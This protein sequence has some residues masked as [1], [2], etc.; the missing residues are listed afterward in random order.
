MQPR[1]LANMLLN[2]KKNFYLII[3]LFTIIWSLTNSISR[4]DQTETKYVF[5]EKDEN[6]ATK[7][8]NKQELRQLSTYRLKADDRRRRSGTG[9]GF[10]IGSGYWL[11]ARHVINKCDKVYINQKSKDYLIE[12]I[13]IH[14][15]SDLALF[16]YSFDTPPERFK[17]SDEVSE[18][19]Y[20][21]GYPAG[22]PG[23]ASLSL[24][25]FM[26]MEERDYDIF[27]KHAIFAVL[28]KHPS[29]LTSFGGISGGPAF[30]VEGAINGVVVAEFVR[31]G[32][33]GV[34]GIDQI[35]W[36]I[37]A[38]KK[39]QYFENSTS[40]TKE[41]DIRL[42]VDQNN[43]RTISEELRKQSKISQILCFA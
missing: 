21:A 41:A 31:R 27:E 13:L 3:A 37:Q 19:A 16:R 8:I 2:I 26:A 38:S 9:T 20:T 35:N 5:A 39:N 25:G 32:L 28:A 14:P 42:T 18:V 40:S 17:I 11:T 4:T 36:L 10:Y 30:N 1:L 24:A 15:N 6:L 34:V 22:K 7:E 43:Y 33:L 23:E 29:S 12:K